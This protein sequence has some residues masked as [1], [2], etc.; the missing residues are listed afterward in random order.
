MFVLERLFSLPIPIR[1]NGVVST[2]KQI[3]A[4]RKKERLK[5][6][7][8]VTLKP[9]NAY[10]QIDNYGEHTLKTVRGRTVYPVRREHMLYD[11]L[12]WRAIVFSLSAERL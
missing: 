12:F 8:N 4:E 10:Y 11:A 3:D 1:L 5:L 2:G 6:N 9:S 7:Y